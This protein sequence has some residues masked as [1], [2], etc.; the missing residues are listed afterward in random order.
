MRG[1]N[2]LLPS[3]GI[4]GVVLMG[5]AA[6]LARRERPAL[7][8][9]L[10]ALVCMAAG[11]VIPRL[12]NQTINAEVMGWSVANM[13]DNWAELR[14]SWWGWHIV[15]TFFAFVGFAVAITAVLSRRSGDE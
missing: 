10:V 4:G 7:W 11:G 13:P 6:W 5:T 8:L 15:R 9:F 12:F 14:A 1:L 2:V 3:L